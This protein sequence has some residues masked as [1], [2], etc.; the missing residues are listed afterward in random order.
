MSGSKDEQAPPEVLVNRRVA[1]ERLEK[2][3]HTIVRK[4]LANI[5]NKLKLFFQSQIRSREYRPE[6]F[7]WVSQFSDCFHCLRPWMEI[8]HNNCGLNQ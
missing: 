2:F 1:R 4:S 3:S 7:Y 8:L 6:S 5:A